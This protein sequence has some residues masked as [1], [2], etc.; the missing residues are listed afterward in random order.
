MLSFSIRR[1]FISPFL[2]SFLAAA[3]LSLVFLVNGSNSGKSFLILEKSS[4][5]SFLFLFKILGVLVLYSIIGVRFSRVFLILLPPYL[6][7]YSPVVSSS[8][9]LDFFLFCIPL[10]KANFCHLV[11]ALIFGIDLARGNG[12]S[13]PM[14]SFI[15]FLFDVILRNPRMDSNSKSAVCA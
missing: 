9:I 8:T 14:K 10:F 5:K 11:N 1:E 13:S 15:Y 7:R 6:G 12:T 3:F 2:F 4:V